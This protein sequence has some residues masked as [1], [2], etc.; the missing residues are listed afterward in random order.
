MQ[1]WREK[2]KVDK[3]VQWH[4]EIKIDIKIQRWRTSS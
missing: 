3:E 4:V 2:V 1:R